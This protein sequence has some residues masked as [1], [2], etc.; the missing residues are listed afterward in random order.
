MSSDEGTAG[1]ALDGA[2]SWAAL[3]TRKKNVADMF[4][5]ESDSDDDGFKRT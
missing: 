3:D 2:G 5:D 4:G 1:V